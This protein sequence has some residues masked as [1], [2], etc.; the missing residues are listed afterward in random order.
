MCAK[1]SDIMPQGEE[2]I[3]LLN[4]TRSGRV[5]YRILNISTDIS[6]KQ[7][8]EEASEI[9]KAMFQ[10]NNTGGCGSSV[11]RAHDSW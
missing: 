10:C 5:H 3:E 4:A 7:K 6:E 9:T 1:H 8:H 11:G 2:E